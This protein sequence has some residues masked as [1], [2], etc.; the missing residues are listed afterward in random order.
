MTLGAWL[1]VGRSVPSPDAFP[2]WK[3][4][5]KSRLRA[6]SAKPHP[7]AFVREA[8]DGAVRLVGRY[9]PRTEGQRSWEI[10]GSNDRLNRIF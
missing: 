2:W 1:G 7:A 5:A 6:E 8:E 4:G 10:R 9:V 3:G